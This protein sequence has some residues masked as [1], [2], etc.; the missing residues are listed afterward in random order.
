MPWQLRIVRNVQKALARV[1]A[2]DQRRILA[3][4]ADMETDPLA[5]DVVRLKAERSAWRRR[6]GSYRIF[7]DIR[8]AEGC[9]DIIALERRMTTTY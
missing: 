7:F 8:R 2:N 9:V 3:A 4:L 5:G 1:P 6:V